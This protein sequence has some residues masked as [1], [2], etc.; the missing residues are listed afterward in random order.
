MIRLQRIKINNFRAFEGEKI[1]DFQE[2]KLIFLAA[3][4][5]KGKTTLIDAIEWCLTGDIQRLHKSFEARSLS[6]QERTQRGIKRAILRNI[7]TSNK[8]TSTPPPVSV[9]LCFAN[10]DDEYIVHRSQ[11]EDTLEFEGT[12]VVTLNGARLSDCESIKKL[13]EIIDQKNY[14]KY[15]ICDTQKTLSFL[16]KDRSNLGEEFSDFTE[17][18]DAVNNVLSYLDLFINRTNDQISQ[19]EKKQTQASSDIE[20]KQKALSELSSQATIL[21]YPTI[22]LFEGDVDSLNVVEL[23]SEL[24]NLYSCGYWR[25]QCLYK[26]LQKNTEHIKQVELFTAILS[27]LRQHGDD[28]KRSLEQKANSESTRAEANQACLYAEN[29][30]N[31]L[32]TGFTF[33]S[34]Y[35]DAIISFG[36]VSFSQQYWANTTAQLRALHQKEKKIKDE[37]ATLEAGNEIIKLLTNIVAQ[38]HSLIAYRKQIKESHPDV[39][40]PCPICGSEEFSHISE[41]EIC[42]S[43][44]SYQTKHA[45]LISDKKTELSNLQDEIKNIEKAALVRCKV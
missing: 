33:L 31:E 44:L 42:K 25:I 17:N 20:R 3:P 13:A 36:N 5:G 41:R 27:E 38:K 7:H 32:K 29:I 28:I 23:N 10:N 45:T 35:A 16:N 30:V 43:A 4:N 21:P 12:V 24:R 40:V 8:G 9:E 34:R 37:I 15:Q 18:F 1:F 2:K 11:I 22:P 19:I 14:Y 6:K 26:E 39:P